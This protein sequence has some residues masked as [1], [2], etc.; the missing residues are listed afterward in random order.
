MDMR[1]GKV[2]IGTSGWSYNDWKGVFYPKGLKSS[3]W[4]TFYAKTFQATEINSSFYRL[5]TVETVAN[6]VK[7]VPA[8]FRFCPKM[9][10]YLTHFKRLKEP[11]EPMERFF[12]RFQPMLKQMGP[13]LIQLH[14][15]LKFHK[16]VVEYFFKL[17]KKKYKKYLFALEVR[18]ESWMEPLPKQLME[19]YNISFVISH[20]GVGFPYAEL[21]TAKHIFIRFHGPTTLYDS[22]YDKNTMAYYAKLVKA[23]Q[24]QGH[25]CWIFFNNDWYGYGITNALQLEKLVAS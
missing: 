13:I 7:K 8:S 25:D 10:K 16:D 22:L 2:Y 11:E 19:E 20:S 14:P 15:T 6:W 17:L 1:K 24:K 3:E 21:V 4:L 12:D 23:W 9:S 18:H 5:P